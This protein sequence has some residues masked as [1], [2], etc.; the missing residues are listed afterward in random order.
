MEEGGG[1]RHLNRSLC[2]LQVEIDM[3]SGLSPRLVPCIN[4]TLPV[5]TVQTKVRHFTFRRS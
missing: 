3:K 4:R 5:G 1:G 2:A